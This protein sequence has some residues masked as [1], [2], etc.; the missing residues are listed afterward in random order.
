MLYTGFGLV[1]RMGFP[2]LQPGNIKGEKFC[3]KTGEFHFDQF[4]DYK[5]LHLLDGKVG[6]CKQ[7]GLKA[8][9]AIQQ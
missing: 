5:N 8:M 7:S 4:L 3:N 1:I 9:T 2:S 6:S